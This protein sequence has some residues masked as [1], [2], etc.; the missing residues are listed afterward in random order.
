MI[1]ERYIRHICS[2]GDHPISTLSIKLKEIYIKGLGACLYSLS[3]GSDITKLYYEA[4][5]NSITSGEDRKI[6]YWGNNDTYV[7]ETI[8][9]HR[10]GWRLIS[11]KYPFLFDCYYILLS[12]ISKKDEIE[13]L[14]RILDYFNRKI[15]GLF[16]KHASK[17]VFSY[18]AKAIP[19]E[20]IP[21]SLINH[22][23]VN[24]ESE[25]S[26]CKNILVVANVSAGKSTL[27][28]SIIGHRLNK[29]KTTACTNK[30][31]RI[32]NKIAKDGITLCNL[33]N[34]Y[35]YFQDISCIDSESFAC[36]SLHFS[37][38]LHNSNV[39]FIDTPGINNSCDLKHR[40]ITEYAIKNISYDVVIYVSNA[41]YFGTNDEYSILSFLK[42][43]VKKPIIFVLN[44]LDCF[45]KEE[46]SIKKM[47]K[48]YNNDLIKLGFKSPCIVPIMAYPA[49]LFKLGESTKNNIE[50]KR[51]SEY[52]ELLDDSYY[53]LPNYL[54]GKKSDGLLEKTGINLLEQK[55]V[56]IIQS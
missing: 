21:Q 31:V 41:R 29:A 40:N 16:T 33:H 17:T 51:T 56:N 8:S 2:I 37:S 15:C 34:A 35:E 48:D 3:N 30:L 36:A 10:N 1:E 6:Q 50:N 13:T 54:T 19:N 20:N 18:F 25:S 12:S 4:W 9:L 22:R 55:L 42:K 24:L 7:K 46:D 26:I 45:Y 39:C 44:Q 43:H 52:K 32:Y 47:L 38:N 27:I 14:N 23:K 53:D 49:L 28:N 5:A 11:L